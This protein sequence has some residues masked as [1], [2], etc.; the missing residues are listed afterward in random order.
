MKCLLS[1]LVKPRRTNKG[2]RTMRRP[3]IFPS[4]TPINSTWISLY[5][6]KQPA[7]INKQDSIFFRE[8]LASYV[9]HGSRHKS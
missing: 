3:V 8:Q 7:L 2:I 6:L 1:D 4:N 5:T 9:V